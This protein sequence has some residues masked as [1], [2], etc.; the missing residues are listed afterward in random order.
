MINIRHLLSTSL[1]R[2]GLASYAGVLVITIAGAALSIA[3]AKVF[4]DRENHRVEATLEAKI[5]DDAKLIQAN[6]DRTL[7]SLH[8][9]RGLF[10]ASNIIDRDEFRAFV[11]RMLRQNP[12]LQAIAWAP[13]VGGPDRTSFEAEMRRLG[14]ADFQITQRNADGTIQP[15]PERTRYLPVRF[16]EPHAKRKRAIGL[17][18]LQHR[19]LG[20]AIARADRSGEPT[21]SAQIRLF[22]GKPGLLVFNPIVPLSAAKHPPESRTNDPRAGSPPMAE[23]TGYAVAVINI[24][25]LM[26]S[27]LGHGDHEGLV[28]YLV[29]DSTT[30]S[31]RFLVRFPALA[32]AAA[33][34]GLKMAELTAGHHY[35]R[36]LT[37]ADRIWSL[38]I[39][40]EAGYF[41]YR[42]SR[43]AGLVLG[44]GLL[45]TFMLAGYIFVSIGR[46]RMV[47]RTVAERTAEL[48]VANDQLRH[49]I[50]ERK[51][52]ETAAESAEAQLIDAIDSISEP[53][54]LYDAD[55]RLI[56]FN[57]GFKE[58][59]SGLEDKIA[60]G[61]AFD[62][63]KTFIA[64]GGYILGTDGDQSDRARRRR[65]GPMERRY[66]REVHFRDGRW[67][68]VS[69]Q[70]TRDGGRVS[71][72]SE[73]TELKK[74]QAELAEL[75]RRNDQ[76]AIAVDATHSGIAIVDLKTEGH[77]IIFANPAFANITGFTAKE[78]VG[79]SMHLLYGEGTD[80]EIR[81][82]LRDA[83]DKGESAQA[84]LL[85]YRKDETPWW[86]EMSVSP[87][88]DPDG[89]AHF[90][91]MVVADVTKREL[92]ERAVRDSEERYSTLVDSL[93]DGI[94]S[95]DE[96]AI[97]E[98]FN[99]AAEKLFGFSADEVIGKPIGLLRPADRGPK[100]KGHL[101]R[102]LQEDDLTF[103]KRGNESVGQRK[104]GSTFPLDVAIT[105]IRVGGWR[106][107]IAILRDISAHKQTEISLRQAKEDAEFANRTKTDF[108]AN[109]SHEL[110]TPLNAIIGFTELMKTEAFGPIE[111][112]RYTEDVHD[113]HSSGNHLLNI[114]N[115]ILDVAKVEAGKLELD[116]GE[117]SVAGVVESSLRL[118]K[119]R[120]AEN[121]VT[122]KSAVEPDLTSFF[123]DERK[124]KQI[125]LNLLSNA[126]K[127]TESGGNVTVEAAQ[128]DDGRLRLRIVDTG[129]GIA[130]EDIET[131]L[132]PFGQVESALNRKYEGTGLGL[133]LVT[134]LVELHGGTFGLESNLGEGTIA[135][136]RFPPDRSLAGH[137]DVNRHE[138]RDPETPAGRRKN[139]QSKPPR[140]RAVA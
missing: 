12:V 63:L 95:F 55:D 118:V 78:I 135:T 122:L 111:S 59:H 101:L 73:I 65:I 54:S 66:E 26:I 60:F 137:I 138:P 94:V 58:L 104:D 133:S 83:V 125:L 68:K 109:M 88:L 22:D 124:L 86:A 87:I 100:D 61:M 70:R 91:V 43:I 37:I 46:V 106:R 27:A 57:R 29:D 18:L 140:N 45:I 20:P 1:R 115:D 99:P 131:A 134:A 15:A 126:V 84:I 7:E 128:E 38:A 51:R 139:G 5:D 41:A 92:A 62:R 3:T 121:R 105:E 75:A 6:I 116:E 112:E 21:G 77:P 50:A 72:G 47:A 11:E 85:N 33:D 71:V 28:T 117:I 36:F 56:L 13:T 42:R 23:A 132:T 119:E 123:G 93:A 67:F 17:D 103:F 82:Q 76:L 44:V 64:D 110:R 136:V 114:I 14:S 53:F 79:G 39:V 120:A 19:N 48:R 52:A 34:P 35:M 40:P 9:V 24:E 127:F 2:L 25:K 90:Y 80:P 69:D 113:I 16:A 10:I 130:P 98:T 4:Q 8:A 129:I 108:L 107:H 96:N 49:E 30:G 81:K 74:R 89:A 32:D 102:Y 97:I 31:E